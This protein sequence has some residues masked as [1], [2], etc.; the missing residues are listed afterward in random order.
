MQMAGGLRHL[1][2]E[3]ARIMKIIDGEF[4]TIE[5]QDSK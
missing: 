3:T 4:E 1:R 2:K 5:R